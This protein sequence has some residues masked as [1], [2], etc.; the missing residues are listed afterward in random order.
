MKDLVQDLV[1]NMAHGLICGSR[2]NHFL[3]VSRYQ[4]HTLGHTELMCKR[5]GQRHQ[6]GTQDVTNLAYWC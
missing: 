2:F 1:Q 5:C 6:Y 3:C 4:E